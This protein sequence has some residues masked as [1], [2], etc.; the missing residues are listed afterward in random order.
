MMGD[1]IEY[2]QWKSHI[3]QESLVFG[4]G[5]LGFKLGVGLT[6]AII[7]GLLNASGYI[8]SSTGGAV[9]P[10]TAKAMIMSIYKYG[11]TFIWVIA[12]VVLIFYKLDKIYPRIMKELAERE[13]RGE[14]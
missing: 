9:Q 7:S 13:L 3:R 14:M 2:G 6:S 1:V 8:S 12:V 11:T 5:S 10:E 4:G